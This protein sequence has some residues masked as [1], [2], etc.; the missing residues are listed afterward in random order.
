MDKNVLIVNYNTT[1]LTQCCIK[2]VNKT[3]PG[4]KIYVF[5]N[6]D[7]EPFVNIFDN[8]EV[9]DNTKGQI[10]KFNEWLKNYP[11]RLNSKEGTNSFGSAKHCYT[12]EKFIEMFDEN[13]VLLDSD[14]L[15]KKDF[16]NLY[17]E[18]YIYAGGIELQPKT[19]I[20]RVMPFICFINVKLCKENNVHYFN[21]NYMHGLHLTK[22]GDWYDTGANFY[23][24]T[25]N[26]QHKEINVRDYI[27]HYKGGSW[28]EVHNKRIGRRMTANEWLEKNKYLISDETS[29][30][31]NNKVIYTCISGEYDT[32]MEPEYI[33]EGYDYVCFTD[34]PFK[35]KVWQIRPI[36]E[37]L[38][39]LSEVK[40]QRCIKI[41]PHRYLP[42]YDFSV[43]VDAN[44]S[45]KGDINTFINENCSNEGAVLYVGKHPQRDCVYQE[46]EACIKI[47]K[48]TKENVNRQLNAYKKEGFP[49]HYG[50]PQTGIMLRYHN[51]ESCKMLMETWWEQV[52]RYSHRD[53]LSFSYALW[54]NQDI[55]IMYLS[56][57]IFNCS[58]FRW[59][60][61]HKSSVLNEEI[62]DKKI[63]SQKI[64]EKV[65][66]PVIKQEEVKKEETTPIIK[67]EVKGCGCENDKP[68]VEKPVIKQEE[69]K[70][71]EKTIP[72]VK[73]EV[74]TPKVWVR[75]EEKIV[76]LKV[77][78]TIK[79]EKINQTEVKQEVKK[80]KVWIKPSQLKQ[81]IKTSVDKE[82]VNQEDTKN[83]V[84][85]KGKKVGNVVLDIIEEPKQK[86]ILSKE[87][88]FFIR[89]KK[90]ISK[91]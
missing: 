71:E 56:E 60:V 29:L 75:K 70:K 11:T 22:E 6:S 43:W 28:E 77:E 74:K 2:S 13:F 44:I 14:V 52:E 3:T 59:N 42:E 47:K 87:H 83:V 23:R 58:M 81:E 91:N 54:K 20:K 17:D 30:K 1:L 72:I 86:P 79:K 84:R 82:E 5:D 49:E 62:S 85:I 38:S 31:T 21:E 80:P 89:G 41:K 78:E 26:F 51:D 64:K 68:K 48:D 66:K 63:E 18:K 67:Q 65:E 57:T 12:I 8:V 76:N 27:T 4:C 7:K 39:Y 32:L 45:L 90:V 15:I 53:Q 33:S 19:I 55:K 88:V 16:S 69:V 40:R 36:P 9:I 37:E 10:I 61:K 25:K 50:L 46:G 34:Q 35:S 24:E 73:Q